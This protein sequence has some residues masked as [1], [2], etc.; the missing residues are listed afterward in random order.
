MLTI[1]TRLAEAIRDDSSAERAAWVDELPQTIDDLSKRWS[2]TLGAPYE[3]GGMCS[4]VAPAWDADGNPLTLKVGWRHDEGLHEAEALAL[5]SGDGTA[6]LHASHQVGH[7]IA[8]LLERCEPGTT[9]RAAATEPEQDEVVA[10]ILRRLWIEPTDPHPFRPLTLMCEQWA[11]EFETLYGR[12]GRDTVDPGLARA[13]MTLFRELPTTASRN[14][15]LCTDLHAQ[16]ILAAQR[17]PWLAIDPKPYLGDPAY[18]PLQHMLN[19]ADRL[20]ADPMG[21]IRRMAALLDLDVE[22]LT[23][24]TFARCVQ[25]SH[26]APELGEIARQLAP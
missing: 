10:G 2:L 6:L 20:A 23:L 8:L 12:P 26:W 1:P 13:A 7:T 22:R 21:L 3:P 4:W 18:D 15:L 16:N 19:C 11:L 9:L 14:V 5:W 25:E 24:W 17:E